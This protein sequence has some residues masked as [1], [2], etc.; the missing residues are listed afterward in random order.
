MSD[1][2][3]LRVKNWADFQHYDPSKRRPPWI[4]F[5][6][7]ILEPGDEFVMGLS[8]C[9]QW[10]L[11]R[12]WLVV[13]RSQLLTIDD[14]GKVVQVV[15]NDEI[16]LRRSTMSIKK[17]PIAKFVR[18]GWLIPVSSEA[19]I[20]IENAEVASAVA[21]SLASADASAGASTNGSNCASAV[22]SKR[23]SAPLRS[24]EVEV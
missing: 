2:A 17:I 12:I 9:E 23:A 6:N 5:Y 11:A 10:Q 16:G 24:R 15:P 8:E 3:Y 13:S 21:S 1:D 19:L 14:D 18:D 20:H 7:R 22:A 4:K